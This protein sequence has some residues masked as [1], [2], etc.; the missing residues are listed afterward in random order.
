VTNT[1]V[2]GRAYFS[3]VSEH[4]A[5]GYGCCGTSLNSL[6]GALAGIEQRLMCQIKQ[7]FKKIAYA[8]THGVTHT[9][10]GPMLAVVRFLIRNLEQQILKNTATHSSASQL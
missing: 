10:F 1:D 3:R 2:R 9:I 7:Y 8:D 5:D 4:C 6:V